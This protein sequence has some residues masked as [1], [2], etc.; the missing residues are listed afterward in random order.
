[1]LL[2][3]DLATED[4]ARGEDDHPRELG[5]QLRESLIVELLGI[6]AAALAYAIGLR[7]CLR[8]DVGRRSLGRLGHPLGDRLRVSPGI[9]E[10]TL[11]LRRHALALGF[12]RL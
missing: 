12:G 5:S 11:D 8:A 2:G 6:V 3:V 10:E 9:T 4:A 1:M 7:L